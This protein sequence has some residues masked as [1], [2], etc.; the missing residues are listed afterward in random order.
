MLSDKTGRKKWKETSIFCML[1]FTR[2]HS[3]NFIVEGRSSD[4]LHPDHPS[5][6]VQ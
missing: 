1:L 4:L 6:F 2:K 3:V 5:R